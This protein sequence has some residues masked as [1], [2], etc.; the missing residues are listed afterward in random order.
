MRTL[1]ISAD[2]EGCAGVTS[3]HALAPERWEWPAARRWMTAEVVTA[4]G[5]A[6]AA[7]YD[8]VIVA[9]GHG[10]ACNIDPDC[11]PD[12]VRIVR[13][14]PRPLLQ[15]QGVEDPNVDACAFIGYHAAAF[16][17]DSVLAHTYHGG[18]YRSITLNGVPC[19][20]GY[21]NAAV[22][23]E[24]GRPVLF[25]S[26][27]QYTVEDARR[28]APDAVGF[29]AKHSISARSQS[30]LPPSQTCRMLKEAMT[31]ALSRPRPAPF[32][33]RGP[34]R[35]EIEM[36]T[37]PAAEVLAY[38]P[39]VERISAYTIA[40]TFN[41]VDAVMRFVSFGMLYSPTGAAPL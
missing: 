3:L 4:A 15:M 17:R 5:V 34:F 19:S 37:H 20:E 1:F 29:V 33:L 6:F 18:A 39:G 13:S 14:W 36:T 32:T 35:L 2:M 25:V 8:E 21:L 28:Y 31:T 16:H 30:S 11:L 26:G 22:A 24:L 38:L 10:N 7:G 12:N 40:A 23:G 41:R 9:D 27:D